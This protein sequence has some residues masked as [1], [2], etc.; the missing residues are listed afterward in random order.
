MWIGSAPVYTRGHGRLAADLPH[1]IFV[2]LAVLWVAFVGYFLFGVV[3]AMWHESRIL[4][5]ALY[6]VEQIQHHL[7]KQRLTDSEDSLGLEARKLLKRVQTTFR[8]G[9]HGAPRAS[10]R[11]S[12]VP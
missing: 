11:S 7:A 2:I 5:R 12:G 10:G 6:K 1:H 9:P 8:V 3:G 4:N